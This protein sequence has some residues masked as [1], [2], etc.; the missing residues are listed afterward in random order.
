M[1]PP[2]F[3]AMLTHDQPVNSVSPAAQIHNRAM[4]PPLLCSRGCSVVL[5]RLPITPAGGEVP[6][7][8]GVNRRQTTGGQDQANAPMRRR[9]TAK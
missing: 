6:D 8:I 9:E 3:S 7:I 2:S 4:V 5:S 1:P